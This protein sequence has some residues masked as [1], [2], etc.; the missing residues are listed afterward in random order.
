MV[1]YIQYKRLYYGQYGDKATASLPGKAKDTIVFLPLYYSPVWIH[2]VCYSILGSHKGPPN[3]SRATS[4]I[5]QW[6]NWRPC[7]LNLAQLNICGWTGCALHNLEGAVNAGSVW[8]ASAEVGQ[9]RHP[10]WFSCEEEM[11]S[12][13]L[14]WRMYINFKCLS[15]E[16]I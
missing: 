10:L 2:M 15:T 13:C 16:N 14:E 11:V 9:F 1:F 7:R 6:G 12:C 8:M 4:S 5:C 3:Q